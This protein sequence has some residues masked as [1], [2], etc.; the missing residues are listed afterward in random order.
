MAKKITEH[1][2][3]V[4]E[5]C[6]DCIIGTVPP[7]FK[8]PYNHNRDDESNRTGLTCQDESLTDQSFKEEADINT[9]IERVK[10]GGTFNPPLPEHFGNAFEIPTLLEARTRIAENNATF[11]KLPPNIRAEFLNDPARWEERVIKD[12]Q[13]NNLDDLERMG[14]DMSEV[15]Q[16]ITI[17][18]EAHAKAEDE[19]AEKQL[20]ALQERLARRATASQGGSPAPGTPEGPGG[21]TPPPGARKD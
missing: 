3:I 18:Q 1:G 20:S 6:E 4:D 17:L 9:I 16:R 2:E 7:F 8:T 13:E 14:I 5:N 15:R 11:Y 19:Q 10:R 12:V 21:A